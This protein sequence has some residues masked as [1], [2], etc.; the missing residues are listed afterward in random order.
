VIVALSLLGY[1]A[2]LL[3][4]GAGMLAGAR[5]PD[6]APRLAI[7]AWFVLTGSAVISVLGGA[8]ALAVPT[9]RVSADLSHLLAA[10]VMALRARYAHPGGA[11]L[12]GVGAVLALAV[13]ARI[14]WC[15][16]R[17]FAQAARSRRRHMARLSLV[18]SRDP[19]LGAMIVRHHQ[20]AAYCFAGRGSPIVLTTGAVAALDAGQLRAVLAH[21]RA[22]LRGHHHL[23]V[24]LMSAIQA[25]F[26]RVAAF[27]VAREQ[28]AR[29][30]ASSARSSA[31]RAAHRLAVAGA[32][33]ELGVHMPAAALGAAGNADAAR[34]R[35]LIEGPPAVSRIRSAVVA[36]AV[37]ALALVPLLLLAGPAVSA[38]GVNYCLHH[39]AP[40]AAGLTVA[41]RR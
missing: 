20:P 11:A 9:V 31:S 2:L 41:V 22:H 39:P 21:E 26:P 14:A 37:A 6:S 40:A 38:L 19:D 28:V 13:T 7:A 15:V 12:A 25:A 3:T 17:A 4:A 30:A 1:A 18:G 29:L 34:V 8:V 16:A 36:C 23:L 33:L 32:L 10:C 24:N 35:R 27:R 5:W